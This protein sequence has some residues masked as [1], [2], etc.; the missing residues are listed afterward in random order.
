MFLKLRKWMI[1]SML[2]IA[3]ITVTCSFRLAT[4]TNAN[5]DWKRIGEGHLR[6]VPN[7]TDYLLYPSPATFFKR[8]KNS[9][10]KEFVI[11]TKKA[12]ILHLSKDKLQ[13]I[14]ARMVE[15]TVQRGRFK[16]PTMIINNKIFLGNREKTLRTANENMI[17]DDEHSS[18]LWRVDKQSNI[19]PLI[20]DSN[21]AGITI[22][23]NKMNETRGENKL[24]L[25]W[26]TEPHMLKKGQQIAFASNKNSV[27]QGSADMSLYTINEDGTNERLLVDAAKYGNQQVVG[28]GDDTIVSLNPS[29]FN[30]VV[31][32]TSSPEIHEYPINGWA[33]SVSPSGRFVLFRQVI[34]VTIMPDL[35]VYDIEK[36]ATLKIT[37][38]PK[39]HFYNAGGEWSE[40]GSRFAFIANGEKQINKKNSL[41]R[42][43]N[44]LVVLDTSDMTISSLGKPN[45]AASIYPSASLSWIG[46]SNILIYLD[47]DSAWIATLNKK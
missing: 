12:Y 28:V 9:T 36:Q 46:S 18:N 45:Q 47:D 26:A 41:Y 13:I 2:F 33:E 37:G 39:N 22:K 30:I 7:G 6:V 3:A 5:T 11:K 32:S 24:H 20:N 19:T 8:G 35:Y 23:M 17:T 42:D 34:D 21:A 1:I 29:K 25:V 14:P 4:T 40:D 44:V 43:N 10:G 15:K 16:F 31:S 38:M 27:L